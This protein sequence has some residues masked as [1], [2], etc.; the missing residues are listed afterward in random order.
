LIYNRWSLIEFPKTWP[1]RGE[2]R[3]FS[4]MRQRQS[5]ISI[6]EIRV[7]RGKKSSCDCVILTDCTV[8][9]FHLKTS[10]IVIWTW[11]EHQALGR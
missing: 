8:F 1:I 4:I 11:V 2:N 5:K 9:I 7:I 10:L 6:R 3:A